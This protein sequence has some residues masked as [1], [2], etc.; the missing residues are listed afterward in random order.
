MERDI[1]RLVRD[2]LVTDKT[3]P[4]SQKK[5]LRVLTLAKA[6]HH[7]LKTTNRLP[8]DQ[9]IYHGLLKAR[10]ARHDADLY[11]LYY[12]EAAR[13]RRAGGRPL[14]VILDYE[15]KRNLNRDLALLDEVDVAGRVK[16]SMYLRHH[17]RQLED[18]VCEWTNEKKYRVNKLLARLIARCDELGLHLKAYDPKQNLQVSAYITTLVMNHLFTGKFKR[19]K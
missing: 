10:E 11:R 12:K 2:G 18:A 5:T 8:E 9:V 6:G 14:R 13:I 16:A 7:L 17:R 19:T 3:I 1:R 4:I 15:L